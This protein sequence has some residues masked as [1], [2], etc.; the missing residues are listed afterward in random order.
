MKKSGIYEENTDV[1]LGKKQ[2]GR[3]GS[4]NTFP[5]EK[6]YYATYC[7]GL[8]LCPFLSSFSQIFK[9][10]CSIWMNRTSLF[11]V[12][13]KWFYEWFFVNRDYLS[14]EMFKANNEKTQNRSF[15]ELRITKQLFKTYHPLIKTK[16][17]S[18]KESNNFLWK[19]RIIARKKITKGLE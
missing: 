16:A 2:N 5:L 6:T 14:R 9:D 11:T 8:Y 19:L 15:L 1:F 7:S 12:K 3:K 10:K 17:S 13:G 18:E 4:R